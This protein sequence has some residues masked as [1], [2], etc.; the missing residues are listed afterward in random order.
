MKRPV[1]PVGVWAWRCVPRP[2]TIVARRERETRIVG[3]CGEGDGMR[4]LD[5]AL[6][7][8]MVAEIHPRLL[9]RGYAY[10]L[11]KYAIEIL[12]LDIA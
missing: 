10:G 4:A 11:L 3:W 8:M 6:R 9:T 12:P 1:R 2:F 5:G 7:S